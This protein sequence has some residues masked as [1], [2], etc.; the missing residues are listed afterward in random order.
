MKIFTFVFT[1]M[2]D[3]SWFRNIRL[4]GRRAGYWL[5]F[6]WLGKRWYIGFSVQILF[7]TIKLKLG[8]VANG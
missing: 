4:G 3:A 7:L 1:I 2:Y 5:R 8:M 6:A